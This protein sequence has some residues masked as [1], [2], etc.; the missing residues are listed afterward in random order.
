MEIDYGQGLKRLRELLSRNN[1]SALQEFHLLQA[2]LIDNLAD[3]RSYGR[4][5]TNSSQRARIIASLNSFLVEQLHLSISFIDLCALNNQTD[6][7]FDEPDIN[8]LPLPSRDQLVFWQTGDKVS[9]QGQDYWIDS[10]VQKQWFDQQRALY[11]QAPGR[12]AQTGQ[13]VWLKQCQTSLLDE[14]TFT[15][16]RDLEKE[17]RLLLKLQQEGQRDFPRWLGSENTVQSATLVYERLS[18]RSLATVFGTL[19][20]PLDQHTTRRLLVGRQPLVQMLH[21]LHTKLHCSHRMLTPETLL[22]QANSHKIILSGIGLAARTV[23]I[24]EGPPLYQAPEQIHGL[25]V[26][27][28]ATDIYQLSTVFYHLLTGQYITDATTAQESH[29]TP[30]LD[31]ILRKAASPNPRD[32]WPDVHAFSQALRQSGY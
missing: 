9:V 25:P 8:S 18:G 13:K 4:D 22:L 15:L 12:H 16:K 24:G 11:Q 17:G 23:Q 5:D 6:K 21:V 2:R 7:T 1:A 27:D 31:R 32:R 14:A 19:P 10:P 28:R 26:P 20:K 30:E 3:Q 29:L